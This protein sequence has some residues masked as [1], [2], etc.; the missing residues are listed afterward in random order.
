M[1]ITALI[2]QTD[3]RVGQI[4]RLFVL[5]ARSDTR[6][7]HRAPNLAGECDRRPLLIGRGQRR[8]EARQL[9]ARRL[10]TSQR[11]P[12][13]DNAASTSD[14]TASCEPH[15]AGQHTALT[16]EEA[17]EPDRAHTTRLCDVANLGSTRLGPP[18]RSGADLWHSR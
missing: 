13:A 10:I 5:T 11:A 9:S 17:G 8:P 12:R 6:R 18:N 15:P 1:M 2:D 7:R 4:P 16:T 3:G 14:T